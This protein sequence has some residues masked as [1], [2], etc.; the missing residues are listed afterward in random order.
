MCHYQHIQPCLLYCLEIQHLQCVSS[1]SASHQNCSEELLGELEDSNQNYKA[2]LKLVSI[3]PA[4]VLL[5]SANMH[6]AQA[7]L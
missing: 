3:V 1:I 7:F 4:Y 5:Y 2:S 6:S